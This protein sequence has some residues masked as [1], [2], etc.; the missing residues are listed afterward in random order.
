M[1][2]SSWWGSFALVEGD[3]MENLNATF[4]VIAIEHQV[5]AGKWPSEK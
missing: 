3:Y 5:K 4:S 1:K 2:G